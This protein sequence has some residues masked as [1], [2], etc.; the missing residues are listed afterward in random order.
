MLERLL[1]NWPLKLLAL[2]L[3][4]AV[5]VAVTGDSRVLQVYPAPL[6]IKLPA[7]CVLAGSAPTKVSVSLRGPESLIRQV[8]PFKL[9]FRV[10]VTD[11][12]PGQRNVQLV[13]ESL[14]GLSRGIEVVQIEPDRLR[15]VVDRRMQRVLPVAPALVGA[16]PPG[17][18]FYGAQVAPDTLEVEGPQT[19]VVGLDRIRTD[20]IHLEGRT[21]PFVVAVNAVPDRP[22][23]R[24]IEPREISVQVEVDV[25]PVKAAFDSVPVVFAAQEYA[26]TA[27]P[28]SVRVVLSGPP[29]V[30]RQIRPTQIRPVADVSGLVPRREPYA[31]RLRME[32]AGVAAPDLARITVRSVSHPE[33]DVRVSSRR[34]AK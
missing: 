34:I 25:A 24:V 30:L 8:D 7:G 12:Q 21:A 29:S 13:A 32:F 1:R 20:P 26:A 5:W 27:Q 4:F 33:T 2:G 15:L 6:D 3:A 23:T 28:S 14:V 17:Y 22:G 10:D 18:T 11:A 19:E 31:V 16:P 9:A